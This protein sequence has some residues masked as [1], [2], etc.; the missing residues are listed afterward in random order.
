MMSSYLK[1]AFRTIVKAL[2]LD[3]TCEKPKI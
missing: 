3:I 1:S 2:P